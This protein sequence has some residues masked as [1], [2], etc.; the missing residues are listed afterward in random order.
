MLHGMLTTMFPVIR[1]TAT[2]SSF[3][4]VHFPSAIYSCRSFDF[5]FAEAT[6]AG[7]QALIRQL[8]Y[9]YDVNV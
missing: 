5:A 6:G 3:L 1:Y 8:P 7:S 2:L 9:Y 4:F